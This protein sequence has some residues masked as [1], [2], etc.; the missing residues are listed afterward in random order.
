MKRLLSS[1][2]LSIISAIACAAT[3]TAALSF[4]RPTTYVDGSA[5]AA[6]AITGYAVDCTFTPTGGT[7][8]AC[9]SSPA[10]LPGTAQSGNITLTYPAIGGQACFVLRTLVGTNSSAGSSPPACKALAPIAPSDPSNLTVTITVALTISS[11]TPIT[12]AM[13]PPVVTKTP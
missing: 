6:S 12:V 9:A 13:T 7:A 3:G 4:I 5:L 11:A 1:I 10:T 2:A 8:T